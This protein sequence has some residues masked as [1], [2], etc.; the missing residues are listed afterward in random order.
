MHIRII[1]VGRLKS[2][3]EREI[4]GRYEKRFIGLGRQLGFSSLTLTELNESRA[5]HLSARQ[6]D[7]LLYTSPSPRDA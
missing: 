4:F 6:D 3:P 7:C 1:C 5:A 2:G